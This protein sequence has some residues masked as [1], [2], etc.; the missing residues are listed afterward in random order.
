MDNDRTDPNLIVRRK[1]SVDKGISRVCV[2]RVIICDCLV[3][4]DRGFLLED[5][6]GVKRPD[7]SSSL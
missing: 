3:F 4:F 6:E 5:G 2:N 1:M 7:P